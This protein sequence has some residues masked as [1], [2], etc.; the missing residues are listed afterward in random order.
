MNNLAKI[1]QFIFGMTAALCIGIPTAAQ[2]Q[3]APVVVELFTSKYCPACPAADKVFNSLEQQNPNIIGLS[4]HVT[5]FD[6]GSRKDLYSQVFCDA[7]QN[8]YKMSVRTGGIYTP[9]AIVNGNKLVD[10]RDKQAISRALRSKNQPVGLGYNGEYLDIEL[11][12]VDIAKDADV[13]LLTIE[14][15]GKLSD[16]PTSYHRYRNSVTDMQKLLRWDGKRMSMAYPVERDAN[17][18]HAILVQTYKGGIIA[19]G[20]TP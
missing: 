5:Y 13:W 15:S 11:P 1:S 17:T 6:R 18:R 10:A 20:Q 16:K 8:I 12:K 14:K 9:M 7:R 3:D 2:A 19:A 4:C